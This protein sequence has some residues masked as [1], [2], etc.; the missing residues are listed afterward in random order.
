LI[1]PASPDITMAH[2]CY[3]TRWDTI[4]GEGHYALLRNAL[5]V[6]SLALPQSINRVDELLAQFRLMRPRQRV[7]EC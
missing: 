4:R 6:T 5:F 3:T 2:R 1:S 7:F